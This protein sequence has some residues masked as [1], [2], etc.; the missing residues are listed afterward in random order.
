MREFFHGFWQG[1]TD[2]PD[3][4]DVFFTY[5]GRF[6]GFKQF[7]RRFLGVRYPPPQGGVPGRASRLECETLRPRR[8]PRSKAKSIIN[9]LYQTFLIVC[10]LRLREP[11]KLPGGWTLTVPTCFMG[12]GR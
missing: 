1:K 3:S 5:V 7:R 11:F 6:A 2:S 4:F 8:T 9:E 10:W 12:A